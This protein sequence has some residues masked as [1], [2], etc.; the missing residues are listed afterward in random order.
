MAEG[1]LVPQSRVILAREKSVSCARA[2][3]RER[4]RERTVLHATGDSRAAELVEN[5]V[6]G[7]PA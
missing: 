5:V 6:D 7:S 4:E 1:A 3:E 2:R